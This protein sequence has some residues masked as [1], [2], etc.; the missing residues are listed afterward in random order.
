MNKVLEKGIAVTRVLPEDRQ[1][2][3]GEL[4]IAIATRYELTP[5]Q[6]AEVSLAIE[7]TGRGE[8]AT[9][10]QVSAFWEKSGG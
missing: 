10:E 5:E 9:D 7:E 2:A 8:F 1:T 3:A 4:L 6:I